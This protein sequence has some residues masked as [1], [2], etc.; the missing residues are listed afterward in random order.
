MQHLFFETIDLPLAQALKSRRV[1]NKNPMKYSFLF[2]L[3]SCFALNASAQK[4]NLVF[5]AENGEK[6]TIVMNGL[7]YNETPQTNVRIND[8]MP[9]VYK[10]KAIFEDPTLGVVTKTIPLDP[11][12]EY[13]FNIR[14]KKTTAVGK[15][16]KGMGNQ[17][18]RDLNMKDSSDV[19]DSDAKENYVM[20]F[21]SQTPLAMP[22]QQYQP[23]PVQ[24]Q[25]VVAP[26]P[27]YSPAPTGTVQQTTTTTVRSSG[28]PVQTTVVAPVGGVN[29]SV[30]DPDMGV[31]FNMSVGVPV[32]GTVVTSGGTVQ[33]TTT[34]TTYGTP[35]QQQV[36]QQQYVM[37][38]YNGPIGCPWPM[39]Q[40]AFGGAVST[41]NGQ[42]F[43]SNKLQVAKQAFASNCMTSAQVGQIM[44]LFSF[45][46]SRLD[47][48]K[49]AYGHTY[50]LGNYYQI[51]SAFTFSSSVDELNDFIAAQ[52]RR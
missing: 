44:Q 35:V 46:D 30:N 8:L 42:S 26:P 16:V 22:V 29:M 37:P 31:N 28:T 20:R 52:P 24:Q 3:L 6:F 10:V 27:T 18:A 7:R 25:V 33:Q 39:D 1:Q 34:T 19:K 17:V 11:F 15:T 41:I 21:V 49:F 50:D 14:P 5:F 4:S 9:A 2:M 40:N 43:E 23:A 32:G 36:V 12:L 38:G 13:N 47:F 45:E 48:A 51:N